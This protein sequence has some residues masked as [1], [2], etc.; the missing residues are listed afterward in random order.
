MVAQNRS[1]KIL[2]KYRDR[3]ALVRI[4]FCI[5]VFAFG[6]SLPA[7][8]ADQMCAVT[9]S[10]WDSQFGSALLGTRIKDLPKDITAH[11]PC[12]EHSCEFRDRSGV[13]YE[14]Y[15]LG[16]IGSK[17][18]DIRKSPD[19]KLPYGLMPGDTIADVMRK[20][21]TAGE[22][23]SIGMLNSDEIFISSGLCFKNTLGTVF[24]IGVGFDSGSRI[25]AVTLGSE[26]AQTYL[27]KSLE[28]F[29]KNSK[30]P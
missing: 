22:T 17:E 13:S 8:S 10:S 15:N 14:A 9:D 12:V 7:L 20:L 2:C 16:V 27:K 18:L 4:I 5:C 19:E 25:A 30:T 23:L 26:S 24:Q 11:K 28:S 3:Y 29:G 6:F 1:W 21:F